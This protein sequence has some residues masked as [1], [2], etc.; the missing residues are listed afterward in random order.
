MEASRRQQDLAEAPWL[1]L[2]LVP[3]PMAG[4][5]PGP[6]PGPGP[7]IIFLVSVALGKRPHLTVLIFLQL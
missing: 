1:G 3:S 2:V 4:S 5:G 7:A 6:G